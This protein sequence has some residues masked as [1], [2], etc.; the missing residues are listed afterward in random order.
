M[1]SV[2]HIAEV[3]AILAVAYAIGWALGYFAHVLS[4]SRQVAVAAG[5]PADRIAAVTGTPAAETITA[6]PPAEAAVAP[7]VP[8]MGPV[9]IDLAPP[10]PIEAVPESTSAPVSEVVPV[11]DDAA[12][13][14]PSPETTIAPVAAEPLPAA[15]VPDPTTTLAP[16]VTATFTPVLPRTRAPLPPLEVPPLQIDPLPPLRKITPV[17]KAAPTTTTPEPEPEIV[18]T[19]APALKPGEAWRG[20]I[21]GRAASEPKPEPQ[22]PVVE[23]FNEPSPEVP[24]TL[25]LTETIA[26]VAEAEAPAAEAH[27]EAHSTGP[28]AVPFELVEPEAVPFELVEPE[29][30]P[31]PAAPPTAAAPHVTEPIHDEDAAMRA[32]EGGW[33]RVKA[34][35]LPD[36]PEI[37]DAGA[38]VAAAQTAVEQVLAKAGIDVET[39]QRASRPT[40]LAGPRAGRK[41]DLK[42]IDGVGALDES[43]L[44]NLGVYHF[45]QIAGWDD[46]QVL[47]MENHVFARGR[48]GRENWQQQ[49]RD[50][51]RA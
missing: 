51:A 13:P 4:G 39:S 8:A 7:E 40:G 36:Q 21:R 16:V 46:A 50:L 10:A 32:I 6:A 45:D 33:S 9:V 20:A 19:A 3:A 24:F 35:A 30:E 12:A 26:F 29:P 38:A 22:Q 28:E 41:D 18:L 25:E 17:A 5:V 1:A 2:L 34:R 23:V 43:T 42:R 27:V 15:P 14:H 11:V 47:W 31:E 48:I 49:A 44:N 37:S